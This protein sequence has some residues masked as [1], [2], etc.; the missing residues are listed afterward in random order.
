MQKSNQQPPHLWPPD[1]EE[2]LAAQYEASRRRP[3][4]HQ[5]G[6][7]ARTRVMLI[8]CALILVFLIWC[9]FEATII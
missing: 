3:Q 1:M 5:R 2:A 7:R 4:Q 9:A 8:V 6:P